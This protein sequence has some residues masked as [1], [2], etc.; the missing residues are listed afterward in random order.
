LGTLHDDPRGVGPLG[1]LRGLLLRAQA[2]GSAAALALACDLPFLD[3][4]VISALIAPLRGD[5]RV[6]IAD[7]L[8]QPLAAAYAPAATLAAV[9]RLLVM[10]QHRLLRVLDELDVE[11]VEFDGAQARALRDWDTPEDMRG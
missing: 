9:D 2:E 1:G 6:P 5:A 10:G 11:R 4:S 8:A 3:E 7:G